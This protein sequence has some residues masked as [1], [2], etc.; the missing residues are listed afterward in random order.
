MS[1]IINAIQR[2]RDYQ[3]TKW[4]W[5]EDRTVQGYLLVMESELNEAKEAWV[6]TGLDEP[7]LREILQVVAVGLA[8][9]ERYCVVERPEVTP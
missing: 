3:D 2:E 8:C 7:A 4:G 5:L 6:S 9:L 1:D